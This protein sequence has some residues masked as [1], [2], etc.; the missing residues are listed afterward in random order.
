MVSAVLAPDGAAVAIARS[1]LRAMPRSEV[2]GADG[3]RLA[4]LPSVA[5]EPPA[6]TTE[7]RKVGVG[8]GL[9]AS[10]TRPRALAPGRKLPVVVQ[11][12]GGP[13]HR[14][15]AHRAALVAQWMADQG[16]LVV[17]IDGR[18]T[19]RR[20][21]A[22]ERAIRGD[23]A[24][25]ALADQVAGLEALARELPELDPS[26]VGITGWSFGGTMSALA[27]I[28]RPDVFKAAVAGAPVADWRDYDTFYT[29]R[30]LGLPGEAPEAYA[31]SSV[32]AGAAKLSRPLLLVHGTADDNVWFVHSLR[33]ADALFRSGRSF[34]L[35]PLAGVTH[36]PFDPV[37][38]ERLW[39]RVM[40]VFRRHL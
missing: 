10:V 18:G 27:V 39:G 6:P 21:R 3:A 14:E 15:V 5:E 16:F 22:F 37:G 30:Y 36:L 20:G 24:G 26:R 29:E 17:S 40:E 1:T 8:E 12:Y 28:R 9:W 33:L 13:H 23:L 4:A 31:R 11:V 35:L 38:L 7:I 2:L 19:P 32:L 25:P 34:E